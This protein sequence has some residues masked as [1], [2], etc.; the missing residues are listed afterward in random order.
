MGAYDLL[1]TWFMQGPSYLVTGK[2]GVETHENDR[3]ARAGGVKR[4]RAPQR[5]PE[6]LKMKMPPASPVEQTCPACNGAGCHVMTQPV[7][8][9]RRI[10][11]ARCTECDGKGKITV[12]TV[13]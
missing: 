7:H 10:Y 12:A 6:R 2:P 11:P 9:G 4:Q 13:N 1:V 8:P 5:R 3:R